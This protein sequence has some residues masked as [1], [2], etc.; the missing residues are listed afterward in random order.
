MYFVLLGIGFM[1]CSRTKTK[2]ERAEFSPA[3]TLQ[4]L[5][6][7]TLDEVSGLESSIVNAGMLWVHN[8]SGGKSEIYLI[9]TL[10]NIKMQVKLLGIKNRDWED[11]AVGPG[12]EVGKSY[13]YVGEIGDNNGKHKTKKIYRFE[14]PMMKDSFSL[15]IADFDTIEFTL[16]FKKKDTESLMIDPITKDLF[17]ISKREEP[18]YVYQLKYPQSTHDIIT[19]EEL[20][21]MPLTQ[22]TAAD[23]S[24]DGTE[25]VVKNYEYIYYWKRAIGE[26]LESTLK[27]KPT[28]LS[29][30]QEPQ[31]EAITFAQNGSGF[32]TLSE[33]SKTD[34]TFLF[35]YARKASRKVQALQ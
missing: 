18:V 23:I 16:P 31:G 35:F 22:I 30:E 25:I 13:V 11:I 32:Y 17:V 19:A 20:I 12:P 21:S 15:E 9:D 29:Y 6:N 5:T 8:D 4:E 3:R 26:S 1:S 24:P 2:N 7:D 10:L 28:L 14:E 33:T 34:K 27:T